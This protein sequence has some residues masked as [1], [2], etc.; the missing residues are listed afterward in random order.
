[1]YHDPVLGRTRPR[2]EVPGF[3]D[4][5]RC[6]PVQQAGHPHP[7]GILAVL[8]DIIVLDCAVKVDDP[9]VVVVDAIVQAAVRRGRCIRMYDAT[10]DVA[11]PHV[12]MV[13]PKVCKVRVHLP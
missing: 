13:Q 5:P 4:E 9:K 7:L 8:E 11:V 2:S 3:H 6:H 12:P 1:M 10:E